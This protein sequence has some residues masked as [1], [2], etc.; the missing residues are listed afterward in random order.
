MQAK[1]N[2][3]KTYM[4]GTVGFGSV[5][6][7]HTSARLRALICFKQIVFRKVDVLNR[8]FRF[9]ALIHLHARAHTCYF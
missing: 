2:I 9:S 8:R 3:S 7:L 5:R 1:T 6:A 4:L